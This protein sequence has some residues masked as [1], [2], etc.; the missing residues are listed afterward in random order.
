MFYKITKLNFLSP[1]E[2]IYVLKIAFKKNKHRPKF[3]FNFI[4]L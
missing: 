3:C 4:F 1:H 2:N